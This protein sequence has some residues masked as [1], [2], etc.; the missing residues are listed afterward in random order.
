[1]GMVN[2]YGAVDGQHSLR[3][4]FY[5]LLLNTANGKKT[6]EENVHS[7]IEVKGEVGRVCFVG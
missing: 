2:I 5:F 4:F 3:L 7:N 1:M 6:G